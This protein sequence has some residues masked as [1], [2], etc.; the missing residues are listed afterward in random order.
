MQRK[1]SAPMFLESDASTDCA[2]GAGCDEGADWDEVGPPIS[3]SAATAVQIFLA[4]NG[5][6]LLGFTIVPAPKA[7]EV[8]TADSSVAAFSAERGD[9]ITAAIACQGAAGSRTP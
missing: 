4:I 5:L 6:P 1:L 8:R 9:A 7:L 2:V 3:A